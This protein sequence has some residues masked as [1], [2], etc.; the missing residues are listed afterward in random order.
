MT[1]LHN[2][3]ESYEQFRVWKNLRRVQATKSQSGDRRSSDVRGSMELRERYAIVETE[4]KKFEGCPILN[5]QRFLEMIKLFFN[6]DVHYSQIGQ[7]TE[8]ISL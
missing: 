3:V 2:D 8:N 6:K 1:I 5:D 4:L 7:K